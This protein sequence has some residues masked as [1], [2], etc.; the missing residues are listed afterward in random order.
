[1]FGLSPYGLNV[2]VRPDGT[3]STRP[4]GTGTGITVWAQTDVNAQGQSVVRFPFSI[5][6]M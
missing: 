3:I 6:G 1:M 2:Y 5:P 4:Y